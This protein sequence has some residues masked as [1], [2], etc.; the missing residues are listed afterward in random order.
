MRIYLISILF[1][2]IIGYAQTYKPFPVDSATWGFLYISGAGYSNTKEYVKGD[3][4]L[5]GNTYHKVYSGGNNLVGFYKV[6]AGFYRESNKKI[7]GKVLYYADTS[8]ILLYD[9]NLNIGDTFYDKQKD[10]SNSWITYKYKLVSVSMTTLTSDTRKKYD[11]NFVGF[12]GA[13]SYSNLGY[14]CNF[15][16]IE[17]IGY[18]KGIFGTRSPYSEGTQCYIANIVS[19]ASFANLVCFEHKNVQYMAQSCLTLGLK[20]R[21]INSSINIYPNPSNGMLTL[22]LEDAT[23]SNYNLKLINVLGQEERMDELVK[24]SEIIT[25]N[26]QR[27]KKGIYFLQVFD[28]GKLM[29][30]EKI[31]K[32]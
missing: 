13:S 27:L 14:G 8:D 6:L 25:L 16:W 5:G 4:I 32:E 18:T 31:V 7:Y 12:Q 19:N 21:T 24:Q 29:C 15:S 9:F 10:L 28:S 2:N 3:T 20:E 22:Q 1:I 30:T 23:L 11:F 17:G 26:I